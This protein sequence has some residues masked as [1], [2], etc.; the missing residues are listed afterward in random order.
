MTRLIFLGPPG[1]GKGTQAAQLANNEQIPH[2]ST[3]ELLRK[4]VE[5][6][7]SLGLKVQSYLDEGELV[8]DKV[9]EDLV[10]ERLS[11]SDASSGWIL[12]GFPRNVVQ[13]EFLDKLL[14]EVGQW[15]D[16][17]IAM[18]VPD[19]VIVDRLRERGRSDDSEETIRHRLEVY[20]EKTAPLIDFYRGRGQLKS[21]NGNQPIADVA[22]ALKQAIGS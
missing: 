21:V 3:G 20:R 16:W 12:D 10:K 9:V 8:P 18:E 15:T 17:A 6:K 22:A 1:S 4:A 11:K 7:T 13:A 19:D 5:D 2:I 14:E